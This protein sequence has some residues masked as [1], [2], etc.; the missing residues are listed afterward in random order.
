MPIA[1]PSS[2]YRCV[3]DWG[4]HSLGYTKTDDVSALFLTLCSTSLPSVT[5]VI[6][7]ADAFLSCVILA[8]A[9]IRDIEF[10]SGNV[11]A[12]SSIRS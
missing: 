10:P 3:T 2:Q 1:N 12:A 5:N 8:L 11:A 7:K 4:L 9:M 6:N